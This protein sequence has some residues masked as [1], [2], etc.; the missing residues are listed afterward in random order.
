MNQIVF[1]LSVF[2]AP[3][4]AVLATPPATPVA[5]V[6]PAPAVAAPVAPTTVKPVAGVGTQGN[7]EDNPPAIPAP[8]TTTT[9]VPPVVLSAP[10]TTSTTTECVVTITDPL[11]NVVE[12]S[13]GPAD[14]NGACGAYPASNYGTPGDSVIVAPGPVTVTT[15]G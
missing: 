12:F 1:L 15:G 8:A 14:A 13:P 10:I 5:I 11:G 4:H 6:A 9:T 7:S 3:H 2:V